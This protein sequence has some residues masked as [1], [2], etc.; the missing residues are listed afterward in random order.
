MPRRREPPR[1][2]LKPA[3]AERGRSAVWIIIDGTRRKSTGCGEHD[4]EQ[5]Q[6]E[7]GTYIKSKFEP[8][9][10]LGSRLLITEVIAAY[11]ENHAKHLPSAKSREFARDTAKQLLQWWASKTV[12][13]VNGSA[14][15]AYVRWRCAQTYKGRKISDQSARHDLV[16]LRAALNWYK[17]EIDNVM[18]VPTV[19]LPALR[20][21]RNDYWLSRDELAARLRVAWRNP[22]LRH[23]ARV[24]LIGYYSGTR[25]GAILALRWLPSVS[26][27]WVDIKTGVM[28]RRGSSATMGN[29]R[30]PPVRIHAKLLPHLRR[31]HRADTANGFANVIHYQGEPVAK[32]RRSWSTVARLAG[33]TRPDGAHVL[34]HSCVTW[35]MR[36]GV[37]VYEV[38]GYTGM[39][40]KVLLD[41]YGHHHP[42]FQS[43]AATATSKR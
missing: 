38:S 37:D 2:W 14:C 19:T 7:L 3:E 26:S 23:V 36:A 20:Q 17:R 9:T 35:L 34:R 31:W 5:A 33:A 43:N 1:L 15:R 30:Q 6:R 42:T 40:V 13:N 32:L 18:I 22:R 25:P 8:P 16:S 12:A 21:Q 29:K 4:I 10:G 24:L 39:S 41:T 28:H 27:G 11:L